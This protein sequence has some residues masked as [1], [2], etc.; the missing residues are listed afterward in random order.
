MINKVNDLNNEDTYQ[1]LSALNMSKRQTLW[2]DFLCSK[3]N[4]KDFLSIYNEN[5]IPRPEL[6]IMKYRRYIHKNNTVIVRENDI[7]LS[8]K[9]KQP[10]K[11][12]SLLQDL[13]LEVISEDDYILIQTCIGNNCNNLKLIYNTHNSNQGLKIRKVLRKTNLM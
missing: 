12:H 10:E 9:N 11:L 7:Y 4:I 8:F 5:V 2:A 6:S 13:F 3:G 1:I